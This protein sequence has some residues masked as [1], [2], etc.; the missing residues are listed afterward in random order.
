LSL[1]AGLFFIIINQ[2]PSWQTRFL[3]IFVGRADRSSEGRF[4]LWERGF[5]VLQ[6]RD[7]ALWGIGP[8]NFRIV[9]GRDK[10][11]HNDLLAFFVERGLLSTI[12]LVLFAL[13]AVYKTV[14]L[15]LQY[16]KH[17]DRSKL[18]VLVFLAAIAATLVES[19][20]HQ[21]FHARWLWMVLA[22]QEAMIIKL[23]TTQNEM[24]PT[25]L[26]EN[27]VSKDHHSLISDHKVTSS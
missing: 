3:T 25:Q 24:E 13:L 23:K 15:L 10:Q 9:D 4:N 17:T 8:E 2:N 14:Y 26:M 7:I 11:L 27:R 12:G 1:V 6:G 20:T 19:L 21:I 5:D 16:N 18:V 22:I